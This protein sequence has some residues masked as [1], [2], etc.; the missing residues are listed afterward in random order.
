MG[1]PLIKIVQ[2]H[3]FQSIDEFELDLSEGGNI[4]GKGSFGV[5]KLGLHRGSNKLY[6]LKIVT[7]L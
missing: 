4:I 5:V 6:A 7:N 2:K 3:Q 1:D